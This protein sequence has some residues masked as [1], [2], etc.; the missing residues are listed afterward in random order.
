MYKFVQVLSINRNIAYTIQLSYK[1]NTSTLLI[2]EYGFLSN[3][4][5]SNK[6]CSDTY[7]STSAQQINLRPEFLKRFN[8]NTSVKQ[9]QLIRQYATLVGVNIQ[10]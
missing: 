7:N 4:T 10:N 8:R 2:N 6:S 9:T 1:R 3:T 5:V